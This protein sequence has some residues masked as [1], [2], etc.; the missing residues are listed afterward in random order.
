LVVCKRERGETEYNAMFKLLPTAFIPH[1]HVL[2]MIDD[3]II[4]H[5]P[6]R[7]SIQGR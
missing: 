3:L 5:S 6:A 4:H 1:V 2:V 7:D